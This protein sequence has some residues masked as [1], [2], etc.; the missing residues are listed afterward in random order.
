MTTRCE[1]RGHE[2][3]RVFFVTDRCVVYGCAVCHALCYELVEIWKSMPK[4]T[5]RVEYVPPPYEDDGICNGL[6]IKGARC[7]L[8]AVENRFCLTH[9]HQAHWEGEQD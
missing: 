5:Q 4:V 6:T 8:P 1:V 3:G 9:K 7:R 2:T